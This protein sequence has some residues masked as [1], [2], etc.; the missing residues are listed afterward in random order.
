MLASIHSGASTKVW[1]QILNESEK[2][3][4]TLFVFPGGRLSSKDEYEYMRNGIFGLVSGHSFDGVI[5]WSSSLS[6]FAPEHQV[7]TFLLTQVDVPLVTFGLKIGENPVVNIDAYSGM[8][9]LVSHLIKRHKRRK[10]AFLGGPREHSSAEDRF[11][12]YRETLEEAGI[13]FDERLVSLDNSWTEGRKAML[14]LLDGKN[15]KPGEDFDALCGA[16]DLLVF[17]AAKLLQERGC[18]IPA[19]LALGGFNDSDESNLF[20]PTY[21]TVHMPF[22]RQAVQAFRML[23][24]LLEG[25]KPADKVLKTKLVVRQSCGCMTESVHLAGMV[26]SSKWKRLARKASNPQAAEIL[27]FVSELAGFRADESAKYLEPIVSSF[28]L[29]LS[30]GADRKSFFDALD[31]ILNE[32]IFQDRD[33]AVFQD[34]MSAIRITCREYAESMS[35]SQVFESL[36]GQARVLV[37]DAEKRMSNYRV[38]KEK[39]ID[40]WLNI[41]NHELLC[42]KN[43]GAIVEVAGRWLP[44]LGI[45]SGYFVLNGNEPGR[46]IFAGGF[47]ATCG[48]DGSARIIEASGGSGFSSDLILPEK[49]IPCGKAAYIVLPLYYESTSLGYMILHLRGS[50]AY[51]FEEIR[52]QISSAMRGV[53]LFEQVNEARKR[54]E[55]AEKMKTEFLA[56]ITGELREPINFI[57]TTATRL[58]ENRGERHREEIEAIAVHSGRQLELTRHLLDLSLAQVDDF[59]LAAALFDP[60]AF[61][62]DFVATAARKQKKQWGMITPVTPSGA[63]PLAFG[64]RARIQQILE[65][66]L[67]CLFRELS[68]KTAEVGMSLCVSGISFRVFGGIDTAIAREKAKKLRAVL[69]SGTGLDSLDRMKIEIELAKRIAFLHGGTV[70]CLCAEDRFGLLFTLPYP[71][72]ESP[73]PRDATERQT[74][75]IGVFCGTPPPSLRTAF[76][77]SSIRKFGISEAGN[78]NLPIEEFALLYIDPASMLP[79]AAVAIGLFLENGILHRA[80]F[81]MEAP[82]IS[83]E[84]AD[85]STTLGDLLR[86]LVPAKTSDAIFTMGVGGNDETGTL[87]SALAS[88]ERKM[89]HCETAEELVLLAKKESPLLLILVGQKTGFLEAMKSIPSLANVPLLCIAGKFND[90]SFKLCLV[91]RPRTVLCN[92]C[93]VFGDLAFSIVGRILKGEELLP[94]PTGAII[95]EAI[96]FLNK[97]FREQISRWKLSEYLNT[98]ED[99]LSR[100]FHKQTGIP[101]WEYLNRLRIGYAI[102]LLKTSSE[103]VAEVA[104]RSGFQ[105][106]AY[107][108]R[109]F[110]RIT[111][112]TPGTIRKESPVNVR[113]VQ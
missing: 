47:D 3:P 36:L 100:I 99:Y 1:P 40:H 2:H 109:V 37:S 39:S 103:S 77:H 12:A 83:D 82:S 88:E 8:K 60:G 89:F 48:R 56:G 5:S 7:E 41:L 23:L 113:K 76:P 105:D 78:T 15:L 87:A 35:L 96:F 108:C 27:F 81:F 80:G 84:L 6:G 31:A 45:L 111:G 53:L 95:M 30:K 13:R 98:S 65:I 58:L 74:S 97:Y 20:S 104:S 73:S 43:F 64:D 42:A 110:K 69:D 46:R 33:L 14:S 51:I 72:I 59:D 67:D 38:W 102:E 91:D 24:D 71:S 63:F 50:D 25:K 9:Q 4:C 79:E 68:M 11:R 17:E 107:F 61:I 75:S 22:D 16:S 10:I 70:G 32:F 34:I 28:L 55:K 94:A 18:H 49:L 44:K 19:D 54:A 85:K 101:L 21:T 93:A 90:P 112:A 26:S 62:M 66:F 92:S 86:R 57:F 29:C 52:A 106:Q